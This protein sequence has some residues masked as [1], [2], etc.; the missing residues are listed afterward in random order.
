M[1]SSTGWQGFEDILKSAKGPTFNITQKAA[2]EKA[3][4]ARTQLAG[5]SSWKTVFVFFL[6]GVTFAEIAALRYVG[7]QLEAAGERKRLVALTT[8]IVSGRSM[9][10]AV[11][12][13]KNFAAVSSA[14]K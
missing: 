9:M 12:E 5:A 11:M 4:K 7:T 14:P 13:K 1:P 2:D 6:G 10:D 3:A 8:S